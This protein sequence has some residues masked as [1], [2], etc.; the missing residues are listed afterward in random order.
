[1]A[2]SPR[3]VRS[4]IGAN[5]ALARKRWIKRG[6]HSDTDRARANRGQSDEQPQRHAK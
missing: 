4:N 2:E 6:E 3:S 5:E 1:M